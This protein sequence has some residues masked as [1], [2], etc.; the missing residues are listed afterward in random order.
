MTSIVQAEKSV[1]EIS[2][3]AGGRFRFRFGSSKIA[4]MR[5]EDRR[6]F[7]VVPPRSDDDFNFA[8][9]GCARCCTEHNNPKA[10]VKAYAAKLLQQGWSEADTLEVRIDALR[11]LAQ[12][13]RIDPE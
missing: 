10:C 3:E 9:Q 6:G 11:V 1:A 4:S 2:P 5:T 8:I 12:I 7:S 13:T